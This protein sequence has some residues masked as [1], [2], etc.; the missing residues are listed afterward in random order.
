MRGCLQPSGKYVLFAKVANTLLSSNDN[1]FARGLP[2]TYDTFSR[3][4][5]QLHS[6][7]QPLC[8]TSEE[9]KIKN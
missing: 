4:F 1:K 5:A 9:S 6:K 3:G 8:N 2:T 7:G